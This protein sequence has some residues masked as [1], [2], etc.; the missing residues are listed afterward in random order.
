[1]RFWGIPSFHTIICVILHQ[2]QPKYWPQAHQPKCATCIKF[3]WLVKDYSKNISVKG[4]SEYLQ[5]HRNIYKFSIFP[6]NVNGS[7]SNHTARVIARKRNT[8]FLKACT[9]ILSIKFELYRSHSF[10][11]D[12]SN[13]FSIFFS[14][15][16]H[17]NEPYCAMFHLVGT[18]LLRNHFCKSCQNIWRGI[19]RNAKFQFC[20]L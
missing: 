17:V 19:A 13:I 9:M 20:Q 10:W 18:R 11:D 5:W 2:H 14:F 15:G 16:S 1:M 7:H 8:V 4:L 3:T 6:L 12:F